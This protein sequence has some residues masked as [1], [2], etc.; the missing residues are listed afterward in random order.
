MR[1]AEDKV[2]RAAAQPLG[3]FGVARSLGLV[4]SSNGGHLAQQQ[5]ATGT[6]AICHGVWGHESKPS[7]EAF[8]CLVHEL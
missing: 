4:S 2:K 7:P 3:P 5:C 8:S 1:E 6:N